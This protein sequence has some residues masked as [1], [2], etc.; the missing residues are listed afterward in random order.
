MQAI[1]TL[2]SEGCIIDGNLKATAFARIDGHITGDVTVDEGLILGEKGSILGNI[3]T[4]ELIVYGT[5]TG[6]LQVTSLQI[7]STGKVNGEIQTQVLEVEHGAVYDGTLSMTKNA[8]PV[9]AQVSNAQQRK[10][11]EV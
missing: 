6:N 1:A 5:V 3:I 4:K 9:P 8:K 11:I 10:L 2:I 7:K